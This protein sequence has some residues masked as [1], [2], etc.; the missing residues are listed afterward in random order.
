[1]RSF[2]PTSI[3]CKK[4]EEEE[5]EQNLQIKN[6]Y[7]YPHPYPHTNKTACVL[8]PVFVKYFAG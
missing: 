3:M 4:I 5:H 8:K 2:G 6:P 1:M 7:P